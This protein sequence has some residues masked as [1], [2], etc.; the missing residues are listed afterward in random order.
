M[1]G[2]ADFQM[3]YRFNFPIVIPYAI[4]VLAE[5]WLLVGLIEFCKRAPHNEI[6]TQT[7]SPV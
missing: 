1:M 6:P 5:L 4:L 3:L 2:L 7:Q